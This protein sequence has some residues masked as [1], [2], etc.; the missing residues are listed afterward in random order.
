MK[1]SVQKITRIVPITIGIAIAVAGILSSYIAGPPTGSTNAPGETS[2]GAGIVQCHYGTPNTGP[3]F[4]DIT[5][6]GGVP[7]QGYTP[8]QTYNMMPY[9]MTND[10]LMIK[11]GFQIVAHLQSN[12]APAGNSV[13]TNSTKTQL[14]TQG[15]YQYV[16]QATGGSSN[17]GLH[18]WMYD[19]TAPAAGSGTVIFYAAFVAGN[20]NNA[21]TGDEV[22]TDT[23]VLPENTN[24]V[25]EYSSNHGII[26]S[27]T[28]N[29][30][31]SEITIEFSVSQLQVI[32][33]SIYSIEGKIIMEKEKIPVSPQNSS[34]TISTER[35][36]P[37]IYFIQ[38]QTFNQPE[39]NTTIR[40]LVKL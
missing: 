8:G 40:K 15:G 7:P 31:S 17:P 26:G 30:C 27:L 28:P 13:I 10:T 9:L 16:E 38:T 33:C 29:P 5:I 24:A 2:C 14:V 37:G 39:K 32:A 6:M 1:L 3:G 25:N 22:Y 23:L 19:W 12:G 34:Y 36:S 4:G 18:D 11:G 20:G 21:S 35:F